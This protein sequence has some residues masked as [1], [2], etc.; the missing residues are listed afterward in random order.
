MS[1]RMTRR[2]FLTQTAAVTT[3]GLLGISNTVRVLGEESSAITPPPVPRWRGFNLLDFFQ[4]MWRPVEGDFVRVEPV[5]EEDCRLIAELGFDFVRLPMDYWLWIDSDWPKTKKLR[6][7][8]LFKIR[9]ATLEKI[10]QS[11]ETCRKHGL[12]VNLNFHRA[13]GYCINDPEREPLSLWK[14]KT[15]QEAFLHHWTVFAKR[16]RGIPAKEL[17]FNLVNEAPS[18]RPG[19]MTAEDYCRIMG[20]AIEA[21]RKISPDRLIFVDGL[22]VGTKVVECLISTAAPQSV[23]A[24]YPAQISHYR[25]S[26]V[27][28]DSKFPEPTWPIKNPDGS[29]RIGR[30]QLEEHFAPW[31]ELRRKG[32]GVHCGETGCFNRTPHNV[33]LAWM[34]DV[35][36]ILKGH[37]I[38]WALWNFRGSFGVLDSGRKD[39]DYEDFH[40]HKLDRK[41]LTLLQKY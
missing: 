22:N 26:W 3:G 23:H 33:F 18:P 14:D 13:P 19:Y 40:G 21:I 17:S 35:L 4:A 11:I 1:E 6:P 2:N 29:I 41:L 9:E 8:D 16:Y 28:R 7:D 5:P 12:H 15:A 25:A 31:G 20:Q 37:N 36:D 27:D 30:Q 38:G 24:Y 34:E 39:V 10:D 32:I